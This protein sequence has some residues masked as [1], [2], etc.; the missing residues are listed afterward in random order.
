VKL[1]QLLSRLPSWRWWFAVGGTIPVTIML[2]LANNYKAPAVG[3][4][5]AVG[6]LLAA[7][8][9]NWPGRYNQKA[10]QDALRALPGFLSVPEEADVRCAI[11]VPVGDSVEGW[12]E[13]I[14]DYVPDGS[15]PSR[16]RF[17]M[18]R[19]II[20]EA[21][22]LQETR[23]DVL[24]DPI[25]N[26]AKGFRRYMTERY[27]FAPEEARGLRHDRRAYL[28]SPVQAE[29]NIVLGVVYMDSNRAEDF[30]DETLVE[31]IESLAPFY[32]QL[33]LLKGA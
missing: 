5:F 21:Y 13:C 15:K 28:A 25:Y 30:K 4:S 11:Y 1:L 3:I 22:Q 9:L 12:L 8:L 6:W 32:H 23:V 20:G 29:G 19:G 18:G 7:A 27:K 16:K 31:R 10:L 17:R 26:T 33:L 2:N 24:D 14:T